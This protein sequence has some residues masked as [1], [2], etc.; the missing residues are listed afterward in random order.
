MK[1]TDYIADFLYRQGIRHVFGLTGGAVVH[2]FDS[3]HRHPKMQAVF[4]HH[5]QAAAFAA[6][7]YARA[8]NDLGAAFV[9]TGP[10]GTNAITGLCAAWLDSIP[11][12]FISGQARLAHT[13]VGKSIRQLGTQQLDIIPIVSHM[14][15]YAVMVDELS[16]VRYYLEKAVAIARSGRPGPV[17]VDLPLDFQWTTIEPETLPGFDPMELEKPFDLNTVRPQM[18]Q[19]AQWLAQAKRPV[20]VA[21]YGIRLGHAEKEFQQLLNALQIP[22]LST[23]NASDLF[24][25]DHKLCLG[26]P[27]MFGQRGANLAIQNADLVLSLGSHLCIPITGTM[28]DAFAREAKRIIVDIDQAELDH[29]QIRV[30]LPI[31]CDVKIFLQEFLKSFRKDQCPDIGD[32]RQKCAAYKVRYNSVPAEWARQKKYV[33][34]YV[35]M[36][37]L[38]DELDKSDMIV[39]DGGGTVN[40]TAFQSFR[41][42]AGQRMM[43]SSGLCAMGSGLP[44]SVGACF[45]SGGRRTI[46]LCGDGSMQLNIQEL[47]TIIHHKLPVKIFVLNNNGYLSIRHTQGGFLENRFIGS[48]PDG[49][50]SLPDFKKVA[51]A[52]GLKTFQIKSHKTL[53]QTMR[54]VLKASGPVLCELLVSPDQP[55]SPRQNF[56][57]T[58]QGTFRPRPFE[59]MYP[60]LPREE[61]LKNMIV[62]PWA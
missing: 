23:W 21:G 58:P 16:K 53:L 27:G 56:E 25:T 38:S 35:F 20:I 14:T 19:C 51:A 34:P 28:Y 26:R 4:N 3:V 47:Q 60:P 57:K 10:G 12:L 33:N 49:G 30:D 11:C 39:V 42:K 22:F 44:E 52:Y 48:R 6:Q 43:I 8:R 62:K 15:K 9:T 61:F 13:T 1:V 45:A 41:I 46:C 54:R 50:L 37:L 2:L 55:V 17:W 36:D 59:E 32:W 18:L 40:Q 31:R 5:E 24:S 29:R 7:A